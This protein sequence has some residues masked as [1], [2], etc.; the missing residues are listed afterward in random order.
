[1]YFAFIKSIFAKEL[2]KLPYQ[3]QRTNPHSPYI[4][5]ELKNNITQLITDMKNIQNI[6]EVKN[7]INST[8]KQKLTCEEKEIH[9]TV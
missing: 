6:I 7:K 3:H 8:R 4:C 5:P 9:H 1:M 2:S